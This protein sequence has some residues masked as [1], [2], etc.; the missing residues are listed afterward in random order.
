[1]IGP[2]TYLVN[3]FDKCL[4]GHH[5][6]FPTQNIHAVSHRAM[7]IA[8]IGWFDCYGNRAAIRPC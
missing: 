7:Q 2:R 8:D 4:V 3:N 6:K 1:M 5:L